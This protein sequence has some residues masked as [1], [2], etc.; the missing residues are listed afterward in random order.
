M[1]KLVKGYQDNFEAQELIRLVGYTN[2][3]VFLT[4]KAGTGKSTLLRN[5]TS[6]I[7]KRYVILAST[8]VAALNVGGQTIHS[9]LRIEPRPYLPND[10]GITLLREDKVE[11]L[12]NLDIIIID[13]VSMVRCDLMQAV[14]LTLRGNLKSPFP[15]AGKQLLL[16]GDLFQLPPVID[17]KNENEKEIVLHNYVTPYFFSA[18]PFDNGFDLQI[19]E[20]QKVYRQTDPAFVNILNAVREN[21]VQLQHLSTL[22]RRYLPGYEPSDGNFEITLS[23]TNAIA[24]SINERKLNTITG[25]PKSYTALVTGDFLNDT[26]YKSKLPAEMVLQLKP[27][28]Q[29]M[30]IKNATDKRWV[31]GSLGKILSLDNDHLRVKMDSTGEIHTVERAEWER[32]E[33]RWN[34]EKEEIE[35][36]VTGTFKQFPLKLAWAVTI[37]KSQGQT[38]HNVVIDLGSGAFA[39]GQTYVALSRCTTL[40]GIKLKKQVTQRDIIQDPRIGHYLR[41]KMNSQM[42]KERY[43]AIISGM[44]ANLIAIERENENL[45][46]KIVD[47]DRIVKEAQTRIQL[48]NNELTRKDKELRLMEQEII[49]LKR[50]LLQVN[51]NLGSL[52]VWIF[53]L[54]VGIA[55]MIYLFT[56]K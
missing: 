24:D 29:V 35:K 7:K 27:N 19:I 1:I 53:F 43:E 14:D 45:Q 44:Q 49:D 47:A 15:F 2:K 33:Y 28:S 13:E 46:K 48:V 16:I 26:K 18:K 34:K 21:T 36:I 23:T 11:L 5:I 10:K 25:S 4:G 41:S 56:K 54:L 31:N 8:G 50:Q 55:I 37:H 39:T 20:L 32:I 3:S 17:S 42:E 52:R 51:N 12:K 40:E 6:H 9:F 38:F 22:N 30:F